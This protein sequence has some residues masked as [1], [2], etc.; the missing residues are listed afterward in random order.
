M[1][2]LCIHVNDD[3]GTAL[4]GLVSFAQGK[5]AWESVI[6]VWWILLLVGRFWQRE[7]L[8]FDGSSC[9]LVTLGYFKC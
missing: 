8:S 5:R 3:F 9:L 2:P 4:A 1:L 7:H 6:L